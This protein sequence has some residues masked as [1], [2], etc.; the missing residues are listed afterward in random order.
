MTKTSEEAAA[1]VFRDNW[2]PKAHEREYYRNGNTGDRAYLVR[3]EG[4]EKM[5]LD[6]P[7]QELLFDVSRNADGDILGWK[8]DAEASLYH[9]SQ[10]AR[11][12][13]GADR[14][15]CSVVGLHGESRKA[16]Q[17]LTDK[18]RTEFIAKGPQ[19]VAHPIRNMLYVAILQAMEPHTR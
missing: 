16:W 15:L 17:D 3:R 7:E 10:I 14:E 6:R 5:R 13:F 11:V 1:V 9:R 19:S 12:A 8:R 2:E 18:Q 4:V